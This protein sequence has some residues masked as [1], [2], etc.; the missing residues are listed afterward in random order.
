MLSSEWHF[1]VCICFALTIEVENLLRGNMIN[2]N[3]EFRIVNPHLF[4]LF[5][6]LFKEK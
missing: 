3:I 1:K 6:L 4:L 5:A 2:M